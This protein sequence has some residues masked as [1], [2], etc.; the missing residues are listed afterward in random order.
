MRIWRRGTVVI[1]VFLVESGNSM[2]AFV[3][4]SPDNDE[5]VL[6]PRSIEDGASPYGPPDEVEAFRLSISDIYL[7]FH[8]LMVADVDKGL[9]GMVQD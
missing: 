4:T 6:L 8:L 5:V 1:R 3:A 2:G 7:F 9:L